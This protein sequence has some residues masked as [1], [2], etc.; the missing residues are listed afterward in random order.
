MPKGGKREGAGRK[1]LS[2]APRT[3]TR[4]VTLTEGD[5]ATLK[6]IDPNLSKAIRI[7]IARHSHE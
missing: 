4:S 2:S 7:L 6:A 3:P 5:I 1:T